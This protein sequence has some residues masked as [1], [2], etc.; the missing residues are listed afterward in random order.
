MSTE[1]TRPSAPIIENF[2]AP[3][4]S[5]LGIVAIIIFALHLA[6]GIAFDRAHANVAPAAFAAL[7]DEMTCAA[8][9]RPPER[10]LPYD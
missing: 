5:L 4:V 2:R 10:S 7:A 1:I 3:D 6:G 9:V 8:Q